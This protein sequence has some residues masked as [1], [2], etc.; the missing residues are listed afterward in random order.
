MS[1][2]STDKLEIVTVK[3]VSCNGGGGA[4]GHPRVYMDMAGDSSV[5]CKYCDKVF[6]LDPNV[7]SGEQH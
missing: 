2:A 6:K 4:L 3:R 1:G 5:R 7:K